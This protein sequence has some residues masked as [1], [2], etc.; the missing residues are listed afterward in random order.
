MKKTRISNLK[1]AAAPLALGLALISTPSFAQAADEEEVGEA[2]VV[3]GS[4]I[5][6][7]DLTSVSPVTSVSAEQ[8][9]L[10]G[11]VTL[12][13]LI[14]DLPQVIPGNNRTSNNSGGEAF[15]TLDLRGLG[16]TRTLIL[17]DGERLAAS[18]STGAV[19]I[20]Q[21]PVGLVERVDVV[22]GGATAV[23][24]SDAI[25]GVINF[26]LKDDYQGLELNAQAGIAEAGVGFNYNL[27]GLFGG[28]F[29]DGKGN[30]TISASYF[31]RDPVS[32]NRFD[33]S[34]VSAGL[35]VVGGVLTVIDDPVNQINLA[36][37]DAIIFSGGSGTNPYGTVV[38]SAAN[39]FNTVFTNFDND[40]NPATPG[41]TVTGG[42][43]SFTDT[44]ALRP[45]SGGGFCR[46]PVGNSRRFNF[47]P[48]NFLVIDADRLNLAT[49]GVYEFS[50]KTKARFF[51]SYAETNVQANLAPTPAANDTGFV[52]PVTSPLIPAELAAAL[53][54]RPNPL[55][56]FSF[57]R[58]FF[59][60]GPRVASV[61]NNQI[62][63]RGI[64]EHEL[65]DKWQ[66]QGVASFGSSNVYTRG[67]GNINRTAV[68]QGLAGCRN[69]AGVVNGVGILPGCVPVDI[70]GINTLTP[71]MVKFV[72]TD[73]FDESNFE[74]VRFAA[75]LTG[76]LFELPGGP[77]GMAVGAEYRKDTGTDT[78]DDAKV[79]GEII[80]F[81]QANPLGGSITAKEVYGE[82]RFPILGGDGFPELL[83][84]EVGGRYSDYSTVGTLTN[85]KVGVEFAPTDFLKF[86]GAYNKAARAP[87]VFELF[88]NGDQGF[89]TYND[90]CNQ[91]NG[92]RPTA[93]CI[94]QGVPA[95]E[96]VGFAQAN[97][98]VQAFAFGNPDLTQEDAETYT[99]GG[100]LTPRSFPLGNIS[101]TVDYYNV[102]ITNLNQVQG[103]Q[104][105]INDCYANQNAQ[106]CGRITRDTATGQITGINTTRIN[107]TAP[108]KTSGIDTSL[109]WT[110]P[111]DQ[112]FGKGD[113]RISISELFTWVDSYKIG[114]TELVDRTA[115]GIGGTTSEFASTLTVAYQTNKFTGQVR[116]VYK[117]GG[118]QEN[119]LFGNADDAGFVTPR[120]PDLSV[121]DL[122][123]RYSPSDRFTLT[124]IVENIFNK[125][126]PQTATGT[127]EQANTNVSFYN[128]YVLGRTF[129]VTAGVKF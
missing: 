3:T 45:N 75:N 30:V 53:A 40:C 29:D 34:R 63:I 96:I 116:W 16:P 119:A 112:I 4:R 118:N 6:R 101:L 92:A 35:G 19:D 31:D 97:T 95:S 54:T 42:S 87:S 70:F 9:S 33:Y 123:L 86:R 80:G 78:P 17:L 100:V 115:D 68:E 114:A 72:Q 81:N 15:S 18:S 88:Q 66:I 39:P 38:N 8:I 22:T 121:I 84:V 103:A 44:G 99:I 71:A 111:V 77:V 127:F 2:I 20:S 102:K 106:S 62:Q 90:P 76:S 24:G 27:S 110:I 47:A 74:Q 117:S 43:L 11:T 59:E 21:I 83:A 73:T 64:V 10:T 7:P 41:T 113:G 61:K 129:T 79:R 57:N 98:Q 12:E 51:A 65:S 28:N 120:I 25:S 69:A 55:A 36:A 5:A 128:P 48:S 93:F 60:T 32:Q 23:Y 37:G 104:F 46:I 58:R 50:D 49:T 105:F 56:P 1:Y 125:F 82:I 52:I 94:A 13:D 126:P 26:I 124:G 108:L 122:S 107:G 89:P 109:N 91:I 85:Y 14:N 67:Q